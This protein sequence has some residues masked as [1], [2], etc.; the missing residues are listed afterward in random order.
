M[1][2]CQDK[3]I[4]EQQKNTHEL[5][6]SFCLSIHF[7]NNSVIVSCI[8]LLLRMHFDGNQIYK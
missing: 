5:R 1:H 8:L 6:V 4:A 3:Y 7:K 2:R